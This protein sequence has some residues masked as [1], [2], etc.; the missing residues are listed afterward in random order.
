MAIGGGEVLE[1]AGHAPEADPARE[2]GSRRGWRPRRSARKVAANSSGV[3]AEDE[4]D[5]QL[6]GDAEQ[7][8]IVFGSMHTPT[9]TM[10]VS[11]GA[12]AMIWSRTPG[13]HD[14]LEDHGGP[15]RR[16]GHPGWKLRCAGGIAPHRRLAPALPRGA[17][18]G[19]DDGVG[20]RGPPRARAAAARSPRRRSAERPGGGG[21]R[22]PPGRPARTR[23]PGARRRARAGRG[24]R[25]GRRRPWAR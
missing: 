6:L 4:L 9:T 11:R 13:A 8:V 16:P 20:R 23:S 15:T 10:R 21:R 18:G 14:A 5:A 19:V 1:R 17:L 2:Q 3:S 12:A 7:G 25:R 22:L 24:R